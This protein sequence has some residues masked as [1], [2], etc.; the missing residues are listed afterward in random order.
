[1]PLCW[2]K[3]ATLCDLRCWFF[4]TLR[5]DLYLRR[6]FSRVICNVSSDNITDCALQHMMLR[7]IT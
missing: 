4:N 6:N 2:V 1:M 7:R 5:Q 3:I